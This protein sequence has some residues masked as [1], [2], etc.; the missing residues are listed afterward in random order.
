[1]SHS[2]RRVRSV[3]DL[4]SLND[5]PDWLRLIDLRRK[6]LDSLRQNH[7]RRSEKLQLLLT[8]EEKLGP[9][10]LPKRCYSAH[11]LSTLTSVTEHRR[12][13][14][15]RSSTFALPKIDNLSGPTSSKKDG[16]NKQN[17]GMNS[18]KDERWG[19]LRDRIEQSR[20]RRLQVLQ[21]LSERG[22]GIDGD[23]SDANIAEEHEEDV[24]SDNSSEI[25]W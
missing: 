6:T 14:S 3:N 24:D 22:I 16:E 13:E 18:V 12:N 10:N 20:Q 7:R 9:Q 8:G 1:M 17:D 15:L 21:S 4:K 25:F 11:D 2:P 19:D 23:F 5:Q